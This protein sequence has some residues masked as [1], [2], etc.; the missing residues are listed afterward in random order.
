MLESEKENDN[1]TYLDHKNW[2]KKYR[3]SI[4]QT[5]VII[6]HII[7]VEKIGVTLDI[8]FIR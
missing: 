7:N 4:N 6:Q 5:I 1:K 3:K 8:R 2:E